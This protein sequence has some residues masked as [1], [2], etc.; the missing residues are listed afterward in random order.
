MKTAAA[1]I[2]S[3]AAALAACGGSGGGDDAPQEQTVLDATVTAAPAAPSIPSAWVVEVESP[4]YTLNGGAGTVS[5]CADVVWVQTM[6]TASALT[7]RTILKGAGPQV[8]AISATSP[9][10]V[11]ANTIAFKRCGFYD[12]AAGTSNRTASIR[13]DL[14]TEANTLGPLGPYAVSV[15]WTVTAPR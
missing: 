12:V 13:F 10:T 11:G 15:R 3:L 4:R 8:E 7:M 1:L 6:N 2:L 5:V 14:R 9:G